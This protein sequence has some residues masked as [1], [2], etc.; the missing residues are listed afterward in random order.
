MSLKS[1]SKEEIYGTVKNYVEKPTPGLSQ[2]R[3]SECDPR[4]DYL[5]SVYYKNGGKI[6]FR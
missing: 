2:L 5:K 1:L 3:V 4:S 6:F